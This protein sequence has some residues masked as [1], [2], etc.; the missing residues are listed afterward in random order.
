MGEPGGAPSAFLGAVL[1]TL[2]IFLPGL[3]LVAAALP[4]WDRL[5]AA[6]R[7]RGALA[8]A[9]CAVIGLLAA[10]LVQDVLPAAAAVEGG[11]AWSVILFLILLWQDRLVDWKKSFP[12]VPVHAPMLVT[13]VVAALCG[14]LTLGR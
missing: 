2:S 12:L 8:G 4:A 9:N 13:A 6:P 10:A 11:L 3:L 14:Q 1:L 7:L 5:R